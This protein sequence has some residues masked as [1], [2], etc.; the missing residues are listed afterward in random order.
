MVKHNTH[1]CSAALCAQILDLCF[2]RF[3]FSKILNIQPLPLQK[4]NDQSYT[5]SKQN[6]N[7]LI[8]FEVLVLVSQACCFLP[9]V[10][11][12]LVVDCA[13]ILP[14]RSVTHLVSV[15]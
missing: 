13:K 4:R 10:N 6:T 11:W 1:L 3:N 15:V 7:D 8:D 12:P 2:Q 14:M 5:E 9:D